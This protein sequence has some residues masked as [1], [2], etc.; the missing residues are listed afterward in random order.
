MEDKGFFTFFQKYK[1]AP[2]IIV[3]I[4]II[5]VLIFFLSNKYFINKNTKNFS[6]YLLEEGFTKSDDGNYTKVLTNNNTDITYTY[7][8]KSLSITK[9]IYEFADNN[10]YI[11][12]LTYKSNK[13]IEASL[14]M[15][16]IDLSGNFST[17][18]QTGTYNTKNSKFE[19][20][21]LINQNFKTQCSKIKKETLDFEKEVTNWLK[22]SNVNIKYLS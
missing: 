21:I 20:K 4:I 15:K 1:W 9:D 5:I 14:E 8:G 10:Q 11:I 7:T 22:K 16:G 19:C 17:L 3:G 18:L 2:I 12:S 6:N 13:N